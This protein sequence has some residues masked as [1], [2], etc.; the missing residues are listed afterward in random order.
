[1]KSFVQA[2]FALAIMVTAWV[3]MP[4]A[5]LADK[6]PECT[7]S[8]TRSMSPEAMQEWWDKRSPD[9]QTYIRDLPCDER[10]IPMVCIFLFEPD[11]KGCTNKGVAEFRANRS[12]E[13]KGLD[14]LS[15][16]M[17]DCKTE[18]KKTFKAPFA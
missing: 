11:L 7:Q 10:Y 6:V 15:Q 16:E 2:F 9:Q 5:A 8:D 12:C 4:N 3:A 13:A 14:I 18:F 17:L 1:M